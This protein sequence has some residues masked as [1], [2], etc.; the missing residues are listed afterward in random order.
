[1]GSEYVVGVKTYIDNDKLGNVSSVANT[2]VDVPS[3]V[4]YIV[5]FE[6]SRTK[7][8]MFV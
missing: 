7:R 4:G 5:A 2:L 3:V 8:N 6:G 1:M